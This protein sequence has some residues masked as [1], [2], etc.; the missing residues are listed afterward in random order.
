MNGQKFVK[1]ADL[2][3]SASPV[4]SFSFGYLA[5]V[6]ARVQNSTIGVIR[7]EDMC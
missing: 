5:G 6:H 7:Y 1:V 4:R 2:E 3:L